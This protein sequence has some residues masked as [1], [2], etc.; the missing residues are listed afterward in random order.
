MKKF[1]EFVLEGDVIPFRPKPPAKSYIQQQRHDIDKIK[2]EIQSIVDA[3]LPKN[4]V[5]DM[6]PTITNQYKGVDVHP[7]EQLHQH[8]TYAPEDIHPDPAVAKQRIVFASNIA[9]THK[10]A[11]VSHIRNKLD[12]AYKALDD[13]NPTKPVRAHFESVAGP[14]GNLHKM[15]KTFEGI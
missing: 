3:P 12:S 1:K 15:M 11:L 4:I 2:P 13:H 10:E 6:T 7:L 5:N 14:I 9:K 8:L